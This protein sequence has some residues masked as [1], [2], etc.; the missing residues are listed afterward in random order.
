M[1]V[2]VLIGDQAAAVDAFKAGDVVDYHADGWP[3]SVEERTNNRWRIIQSPVLQTT[4]DSFVSS[5]PWQLDVKNRQRE[6]MLV[7]S[8][9]PNPALFTGTRTQEIIALTRA[10]V[11][12]AAVKKP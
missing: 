8:L 4:V 11:V 9:L 10:Q 5:L 1:E 6:Y 3:W 12:A 2:L 7:F